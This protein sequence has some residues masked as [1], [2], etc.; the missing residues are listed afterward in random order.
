MASGRNIKTTTKATSVSTQSR[1]GT[2]LTRGPADPSTQQTVISYLTWIEKTSNYAIKRLNASD[3]QY[4]DICGLTTWSVWKR[5]QIGVNN[6][7][8]R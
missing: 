8:K 4:I 3:A 1:I 6:K 7:N 5:Q 2:P